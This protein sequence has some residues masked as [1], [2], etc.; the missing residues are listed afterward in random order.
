MQPAP[1]R[2]ARA[3][4]AGRHR[5]GRRARPRPRGATAPSPAMT[6]TPAP[7]SP[8]YATPRLPWRASIQ[9]PTER[10]NS[11]TSEPS[12]PRHPECPP[13]IAFAHTTFTAAGNAHAAVHTAGPVQPPW[14]RRCSSPTSRASGAPTKR[15]SPAV[16]ASATHHAQPRS[17]RRWCS[18]AGEQRDHQSAEQ[19]LAEDRA[20]HDP[21]R[22]QGHDRHRR[23]GT[24]GQRR[25]AGVAPV[26]TRHREPGDGDD[27]GD[28][29]DDECGLRS[30]DDGEHAGH[31]RVAGGEV[32]ERQPAAT[33]EEL[34]HAEV[35]ERGGDP[36]RQR[37]AA[38][39]PHAS[40]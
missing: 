27:R 7:A 17:V 6:T 19:R 34:D 13:P 8:K 9:P 39:R 2:G 22:R 15:T 12:R 29:D 31:E 32:D 4:P 1:A 14:R 26:G 16:A 33:V 28:A 38:R 3:A 21:V 23:H 35:G 37:M 36:G 40:R 30:G 24:Q 20:G 10:A 5:P 25:P 18:S 11:R